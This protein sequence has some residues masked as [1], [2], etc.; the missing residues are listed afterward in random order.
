MKK[1]KI[2]LL[3]SGA[4]KIGQAGE[5]DYSGS[6]AIKAFNEE[7]HEVVLIN[8]N[9]ATYQTTYQLAKRVYFLP[10]NEYFVEEIIKKE[11]VNAIALSFGG[12]TALNTALSLE[13]K[14]V[15]KQY[16]VQ[17][18][19]TSVE[20]IQISEDRKLFA[21]HLHK[22]KVSTPQSV[23][24]AN[25]KQAHA[26]AEKI[27]FP[28]MMR[29]AYALGGQRSGV[30]YNKKELDDKL[31]EVFAFAPQVLIEKY[32]HHYKEIEYEVVR[33]QYDNCV[34][35]CNMENFDPLGVHT[36]ESIVV[37]PSQTLTN[38][39][40]HGLRE[41]SINIVRSL[42]IIG[43][44]NVQFALNPNP[45]KP[46]EIDYQVIELNPRLSRSSALASKAT[47]YP[48][49]YIAA[50]LI[51]GKSLTEIDNQVTKVTQACFEPALDY[52]VVKI[53]RWD[54][55]KFRG[56]EQTI[57]SSMKS[58]GE[59]MAIGRKFEEAIQKAIRMLDIGAPGI[60]DH[61]FMD[62]DEYLEYL[63]KP[64]TKR[65]F[66]IAEAMRRGTTVD[67]IHKL[68]GV[69]NWFLYR[70]KH[71]V[72][73][74]MDLKKNPKKIH[75]KETLREYKEIGLSDAR[76]G[77]LTDHTELEIRRMRKNM[78][79]VPSVFQI[80]TLAGEMPAKTNYLYMTYNGR[81]NDVEPVG[82]R[83]VIVLGS[84]PYRIGSSVEFDWTCV[85]A[86]LRLKT[87]Q[88]K[89]ILINCN[90]ETV[91][92]DYDMSD[93]LYFEQLTF[94]RVADI[95]EFENPEGIIVSVGG[96]TP[97]NIVGSLEKYD[98][99]ILGTLA[100]DIDRVEDRSK[101]SALCDKLGLEQPAWTKVESV[102]QAL[103]FA[104]EVGYPVLIRPSY[105]LSGAAMKACNNEEDLINYVEKATEISPEYPVTISKF[106]AD[107]K[108]IEFDAVAQDGEIMI[109]ALSEH[110]E[111]AGVHS[112]D[113]TIVF[114]PQK[115]YLLTEQKIIDAAKKLAKELNI[116][117]PF[118]IQFLGVRNRIFIIEMN[119]RASRTFPF[120]SRATSR[121]FAKMIVDAI[122]RKAK[123]RDI[124]F[125]EDHVLVKAAQFSFARL[126]GADPVLS[127]EMSSTGEAACFGED[128]EEAFYKSIMSVGEK[129]PVKGVFLSLYGPE[130]KMDFFKSIMRLR[131][132]GLK[133]YATEGTY[134]FLKGNRINVTFVHKLQDKKKPNTLTLFEEGKVDLAINLVDPN[135]QEDVVDG[136][137][138]RRGAI[139][140]NIHLITN[141][142]KAAQFI[143]AIA[144]K[145]VPDL[146]VKAWDEYLTDPEHL[147][148]KAKNSII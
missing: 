74:Q 28:L 11:K 17:V 33:D 66:A 80:D 10:V 41:I 106:I 77:E 58:V 96:Q 61:H 16:G 128:V 25:I 18:L 125:P 3:G 2:L 22:I 111:N 30:V 51:L 53:P 85:N 120:I 91:S 64:T 136:V 139:D 75:N 65:L 147:N 114:P 133:L 82:R 42:N 129:R 110:V 93:R 122:F 123:H 95:F 63:N 29:V 46:N 15:F 73:S 118:N 131:T 145:K 78:G 45:S 34:S 97:N 87:H 141:I 137:Q 79:I 121:N 90:P 98:L 40:Y 126:A 24:A 1:L 37:A 59:V 109:H 8:P 6:Q 31:K 132:L 104:E 105:V 148:G 92:T 135:T 134:N 39:E 70:I 127:V 52:L 43:E 124:I 67:E 48:L 69:D 13:K 115:I 32:L 113:A 35:I 7:G 100:S 56:V 20:S 62:G 146:K 108:E 23:A 130:N 112:G 71:L 36:G 88:R 27:G 4:L 81:H 107:A 14:G 103:E 72:D 49:A 89:S 76:I 99:P 60:L 5:F 140:H 83:G 54:L 12:Q 55:E 44:C 102:E 116:T 144:T 47:G 142:H 138:I 86:A 101:F 9:I 84:G 119:V 21:N 57:G 38:E 68:T 117:G 94:E 143:K 26:A 19:G 50:K